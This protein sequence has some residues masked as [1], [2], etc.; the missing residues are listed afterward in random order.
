MRLSPDIS[1]SSVILFILFILCMV[2]FF[3][4]LIQRDKVRH[5]GEDWFNN[6][7]KSLE[8]NKYE[9]TFI[10]NNSINNLTAENLLIYTSSDYIYVVNKIRQ[11]VKKVS[12]SDILNVDLN[13]YTTQKNVKRL[14]ALTST[15]DNKVNVTG[16]ELKITTRTETHV[17]LMIADGKNVDKVTMFDKPKLIDDANRCK[18]ILEDDIKKLNSLKI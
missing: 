5:S 3:S 2:V 8:L 14:I 15:Y 4:L 7:L 18:L 13:I 16:L 6:T 9:N 12:K 17:F 10:L 1:M 11:T